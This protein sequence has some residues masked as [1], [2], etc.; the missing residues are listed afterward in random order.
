M[1]GEFAAR[2]LIQSR[3]KRRWKDIAYVKRME[4]KSGR[5][6]DPL[7]GAPQARA[8]VLRKVNR[9]QKQP[10][11][12]LIKCIRAQILKNGKVV[13]AHVPKEGAIKKIDEHDEVIIEGVGGA[14]GGSMGTM[15]GVKYKVTKVNG[16]SLE[17]VRK[18]KVDKPQR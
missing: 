15:V 12:G 10:S 5:T 3:K 4:R 7:D 13:T 11:S 18:G 1:P 6:T 8:I 9:E 17:E 2:K 16:V 14:Q